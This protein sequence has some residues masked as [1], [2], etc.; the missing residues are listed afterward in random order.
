MGFSTVSWKFDGRRNAEEFVIYPEQNGSVVIQSDKSIAQIN[1]KT[2]R[3]LLNVKG[4]GS[5]YFVHLSEFLGAKEV[6]FSP[7]LIA[8][9][10]KSI[11]KSGDEIG[12]GVYFG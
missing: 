2:G 1:L 5:K 10:K 4:G 7:S 8:L 12:G 11:P 6:K 9:I 3:G